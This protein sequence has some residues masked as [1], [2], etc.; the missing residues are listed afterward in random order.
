[1]VRGGGTTPGRGVTGPSNI[2]EAY[3]VIFQRTPP[4][5]SDGGTQPYRGN[6]DTGIRGWAYGNHGSTERFSDKT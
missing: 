5:S 4:V 6:R 2:L 1:M 3:G